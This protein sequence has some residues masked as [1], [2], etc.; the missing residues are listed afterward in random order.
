M[1]WRRNAAPN[2]G[3]SVSPTKGVKVQLLGIGIGPD[4]PEPTGVVV[5]YDSHGQLDS[6]Q[7]GCPAVRIDGFTSITC[8]AKSKATFLFPPGTVIYGEVTTKLTCCS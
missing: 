1:T 7:T 3:S 8:T 6:L 2:L 5:E 4:G